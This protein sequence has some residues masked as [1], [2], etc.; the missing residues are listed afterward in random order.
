MEDFF[1]PTED[2]DEDETEAELKVPSEMDPM[3]P[4]EMETNS[5]ETMT[6]DL[7][8]MDKEVSE[9]ENVTAEMKI[10]QDVNGDEILRQ[11]IEE[12]ESMKNYGENF[13]DL[14]F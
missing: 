13:L 5:N 9:L 3:V 8:L 2:E 7:E 10:N 14:V 11:E 1:G 6:E 4:N 12:Y